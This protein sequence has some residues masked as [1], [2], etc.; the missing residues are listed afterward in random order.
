MFLASNICWVSSAELEALEAIARLGLLTHN[1]EH[2]VDK[3]STLSV[4]TLGPIVTRTSLA[5]DKVVGAE[6]LTEGA[7]TH[8]VHGTRLEIHQD[9]TGHV[10]TAGGLVVVHV[11]A[12]QL[13]VGVTVIGSGRV[14]AMLVGDHLPKLG[15][16]LVT[17]LAS[18]NVN[19]LAHIL[20]FDES[21]SH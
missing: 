8:G 1:I 12:L 5:E 21:I 14:D 18:L 10:A 11:D 6:E 13:K 4:V 7:G 20:Y 2:G 19:E 9:G 17:A 3:L 16:N 15:T